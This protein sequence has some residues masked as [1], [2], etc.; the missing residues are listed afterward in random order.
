MIDQQIEADFQYT[1]IELAIWYLCAGNLFVRALEREF[2]SL[3]LG[4][5]SNSNKENWIFIIT[6]TWM[7]LMKWSLGHCR[8]KMC[9]AYFLPNLLKSDILHLLIDYWVQRPTQDKYPTPSD[10]FGNV[11]EFKQNA[12]PLMSPKFQCYIYYSSH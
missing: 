8:R 9:S 7:D 2:K 11:L 12:F 6:T 1:C 10:V 5:S 3:K 4:L